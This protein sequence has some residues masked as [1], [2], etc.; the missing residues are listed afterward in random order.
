[1]TGNVV[2]Q[3][4]VFPDAEICTETDLFFRAS[5]RAFHRLGRQ[6]VAFLDGGWLQFDTWMNL[7]NLENWR[8][9]CRLDGLW[10]TLE[11]RGQ[12]ALRVWQITG[13]DHDNL[14]LH[15]D[16]ITLTGAPLAVDLSH[17]LEAENMRASGALIVFRIT[18]LERGELTGAHYSTRAPAD[19]VLPTLAISITTFRREA[20]VA[21]T[22]ARLAAF[23][24]TFE[25][26]DRLRVQVVDN[27]QSVTL[28]D[29][30]ALRLIPNENLGGAGGFARGLL[31][32]SEAGFSHCLFMDDDASFQMENIRRTYAF[33]R[34]ARDPRTALAGAMISNARKWAM[35]EYGAVFEYHCRPQYLGRDL[36]H[37]PDVLGMELEQVHAIPAQFYGGWWFFAFP[38]GEVQHYPFPF[39]VRGDDISFSLANPFRIARLNGVVSFQDDFPAKESPL[40]LY[41]DLRNHLSHHLSF[42]PLHRGAW[43][44]AQIALRFVG[45]SLS[46]FH[47]E[48]AEAQLRALEDVMRGPDFFARTADMAERRAAIGKAT[49]RERWAA[50]PA[51]PLPPERINNPMPRWRNRLLVLTLNGS[52]LPLPQ[53]G[54]RRISLPVQA[55]GLIFPIWGARE[56]TYLDGSRERGYVVVRDRRRAWRL[57]LRLLR[58]VLA[59]RRDYPR[60]VQSYGSGYPRIASRSF[61]QERLGRAA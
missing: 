31:E 23:V 45:R 25:H 32:A 11:G 57:V 50:L 10:L 2:L 5:D 14:L 61:W 48:S 13:R 35:W 6:S 36:R 7:F 12:M 4:I 16:L 21:R 44:T 29:H 3:E 54:P 37:M 30:P 56:I 58:L 55:R 1:M 24:D 20:D 41:L 33:L 9:H 18:A 19:D 39:F 60:L 27:G 43:K 38:V 8:H 34:L 47:Y 40:T 17:A 49:Q 46:R 59:L 26:G 52:L 53:W 22:A 15:D 51:G 28:P 42:A